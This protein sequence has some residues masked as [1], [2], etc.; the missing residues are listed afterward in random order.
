MTWS[1]RRLLLAAG[2]VG[3]GV[4][5]C[6]PRAL[7][8]L[9]GRLVGGEQ[10]ERGHRIRTALPAGWTAPKSAV[11]VVIVGGGVAGLAAAWRLGRA[12]FRGT[13]ALLELA[14]GV[15]GTSISGEDGVTPHPWGAHYLVMPSPG[16]RHVRTLL[17]EF[18][19]IT[20]FDADGRPFYDPTAV[21]NA[22]Q[23]RL[24]VDGKWEDGVL[25]PH[26]SAETDAQL[27]AF[28]AEIER[29]RAVVGADGLPAF[30]I[31]V[32]GSSADPAL[33]ALCGRSLAAWLDDLGL[34][35]PILRAALRYDTRDDF[36]TELNDTNAWAGLHYHCARR[37]DPADARDLGTDVLT[38]PGGNGWLVEQLRR[39]LTFAPTTGAVVRA[40]VP[41][42]GGVRVAYDALD[43]L[44]ELTAGHVIC[45]VPGRVAA[46]L[47]DR[48]IAAPDL[49][50]WRIA[51]LH[52]DAPPASHGVRIAWDSVVW[53]GRGVGYVSSA[54]QLGAYGGPSVLTYYDPCSVGAPA[55]E[56]RALA[57]MSWEEHADLVFQDLGPAHWDLRARVQ[58]LDVRA[59]GHGTAR[60]AIGE[61][62]A[63]F[64]AAARPHP[65]VSLAH[66]DRS[67]MSLFEEAS[68]HG[69]RAAEEALVALGVPAGGTLL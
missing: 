8:P 13:V 69:I 22:P 61:D 41:E 54:H 46:R 32:H 37:P 28:D 12:G 14:D 43:G 67:G 24:F 20:G 29:L 39:R 68:W 2:A 17:R 44:R 23:E 5:A 50:P 40:I 21:A 10:A 1:R 51:Q 30:S 33:R 55:D 38:W 45:A 4:T 18:G 34:D 60:P 26:R 63:S 58:R 6:A 15:G 64:L 48:P 65:R 19:V 47:L 49:A 52:V 66:T 27:A 7:P 11:D 16:A 57:E 3:A 31:P 42:E 62:P 56:R 59:W 36:G 35:D 9:R 53:G 25:P